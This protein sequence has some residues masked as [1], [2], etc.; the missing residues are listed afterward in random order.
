MRVSRPGNAFSSKGLDDLIDKSD[1]RVKNTSPPDNCRSDHRRHAR[2]EHDHPEEA[3][4]LVALQLADQRGDCERND[5]VKRN[6]DDGEYDSILERLHGIRVVQ[7]FSVIVKSN[8][9]R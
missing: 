7:Q 4:G 6:C 8:K 5:Y 9:P 3:P 2:Q 1:F